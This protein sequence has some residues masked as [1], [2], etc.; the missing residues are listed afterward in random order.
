MAQ[1]FFQTPWQYENKVLRYYQQQLQEQAKLLASV[2][3]ALPAQLVSAALYCVAS[4][5][6][7]IVYTDSAAWASQLRFYSPQILASAGG[8]GFA[9]VKVKIITKTAP[10]PPSP[11]K[12]PS[13][14]TVTL[15]ATQAQNQRDSHLQ[16]AL[17][18]L[19]STLRKLQ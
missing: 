14:Q 7:L 12:I 8:R 4:G 16:S 1:I 3:T 11:I 18:R 9:T 6:K 13:K 2:K 17:A 15:L 10:V 19:A 5:D